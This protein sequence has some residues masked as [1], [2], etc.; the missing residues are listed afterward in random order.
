[1]IHWSRILYAYSTGKLCIVLDKLASLLTVLKDY[2]LE[3][4]SECV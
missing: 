3:L 4:L 1:M 2:K